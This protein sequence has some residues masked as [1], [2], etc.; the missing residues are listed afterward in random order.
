[1]CNLLNLGI[2]R[3]APHA[4]ARIETMIFPLILS[5]VASH[6]TR[7]RGLKE[8]NQQQKP[9]DQNLHR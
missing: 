9:N 1:M 3:I 4:G 7:V 2:A 8:T 6:P 5:H